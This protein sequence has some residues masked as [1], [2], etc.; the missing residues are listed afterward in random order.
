MKKRI[1][2]A[3]YSGNLILG[4]Q[5]IPNSPEYQKLVRELDDR[6]THLTKEEEE[7]LDDLLKLHTEALS[8]EVEEAFYRG[9]AAGVLLM[10]EVQSIQL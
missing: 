3:L 9:F 2:P 4:E 6:R 7:K 1:L 5:R 10:Q 8:F